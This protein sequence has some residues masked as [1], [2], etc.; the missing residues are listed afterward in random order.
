MFYGLYC[1]RVGK[2]FHNC[3][4]S[5]RHYRRM[6]NGIGN[7]HSHVDK[8]MID[9]PDFRMKIV[10]LGRTNYCYMVQDKESS[11]LLVIDP[12]DAAHIT[13]IAQTEFNAPVTMALLTHKHWDHSGG[14]EGLHKQYPDLRSYVSELEKC[15]D[16]QHR[17]CHG[18]LLMLGRLEIRAIHTPGHTEGSMCYFIDCIASMP[19]LFTGDT[20]F[21][22]GVG[23]FFEGNSKI[24]LGTIQK[25]LTLPGN[26]LVFPGH[27]YS[28]MTLKFA[29]YIEPNNQILKN[30]AKWVKERRMKHL[31]TI[32]S[33]WEEE[34]SYNPFLRIMTHAVQ[35]KTGMTVPLAVL[36]MLHHM[37]ITRREEY[38]DIQ[39]D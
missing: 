20:L 21:L 7:D 19:L 24:F 28:D 27:E 16:A 26:T 12:E 33:T 9:F 15:D 4:L 1:S 6:E 5:N 3:I 13:F 22:G 32:P 37:R 17:L 36:S 31:C 8:P 30:K 34:R 14:L 2:F 29:L 25:L 23:A 39:L 18:D 10:P 11:Q 38:R 35:E